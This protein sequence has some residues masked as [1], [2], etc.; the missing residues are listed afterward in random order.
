MIRARGDE[1]DVPPPGRGASA[2]SLAREAHRAIRRGCIRLLQVRHDVAVDIQAKNHPDVMK[3]VEPYRRHRTLS[4]AVAGESSHQHLEAACKNLMSWDERYP[5]HEKL[6]AVWAVESE[7]TSL[8]KPQEGGGG[9]L[10]VKH[11]VVLAAGGTAT[12]VHTAIAADVGPQGEP[13]PRGSNGW[14]SYSRGV[15]GEVLNDSDAPT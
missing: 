9:S 8:R 15:G 11:S 2:L 1:R 13:A 5:Q 10:H 12:I 4:D 7:R 6:G 3:G 14:G